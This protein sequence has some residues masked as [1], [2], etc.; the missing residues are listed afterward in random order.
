MLFHVIAA[1]AQT[2]VTMHKACAVGTLGRAYVE[3]TCEFTAE[4]GYEIVPGSVT[5]GWRPYREPTKDCA[6]SVVFDP[7]EVRR[8]RILVHAHAS[9][10]GGQDCGGVMDYHIETAAISAPPPVG[11]SSEPPRPPDL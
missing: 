8:D 11:S 2:I 7:P 6:G 4:P 1:D 3:G 5:F 10:R 9:Q